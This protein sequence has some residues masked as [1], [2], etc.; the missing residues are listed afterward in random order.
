[1]PVLGGLGATWL[2]SPSHSR[3]LELEADALMR[4]ARAARTPI[5]FGYLDA[6][7]AVTGRPHELWINCR[8]MHCFALGVLLGRPGCTSLVDHG[9]R[10]LTTTFADPE[11][12]GWF[13]AVTAGGVEVDR[14]DAYSHAF[15]L[16]A[17]ASAVTAGRPGADEL[18]EEARAVSLRHFWQDAE[19]LVVE[20]YDRTFT[21]SEAYR[22][23]NANMHTV[24][25]YLVTADVTGDDAW[26]DRAHRIVRRVVDDFAR[27]AGWRIP[28][29]FDADW[30]PVLEY[31]RDSPADPF[32]PYGATVGHSFEWARLTL[33]TA[34]ALRR[35]GTEPEAW[36]LEG[37]R[38]LFARA[39]ED[40]WAVDGSDGFVYTVDFAGK[41]VVHERMHWVVTEA[42]SA[43]ATLHRVTG[44]TSYEHWY[45]TWWDFAADHLIEQPGAWIHELDAEHAPSTRT[46]S[47]KP[48]I[49]HALQATLIP[50]LPATPA[51]APAIAG[52]HL[53]SR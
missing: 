26:L 20:S 6:A 7:G 31:N 18:F 45:R 3:W 40:G 42:A 35:R 25:A 36:M 27:G 5:G 46:W 11:F 51:I 9:I 52:G 15:V 12:G 28:E 33:E 8:M 44:E 10:A 13:T 50:R 16:L 39:V 30:T 22:G 2:A 53:D 37:A 41:P 19:G 24:E 14:K 17:A 23:V 21:H 48:D 49:Y 32:R 1:M 38:A 34:A 29:H 4:F 43:A 47:G